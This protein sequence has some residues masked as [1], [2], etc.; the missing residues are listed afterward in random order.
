[1]KEKMKKIGT[2][3]GHR[4]LFEHEPNIS[5]T[6]ILFVRVRVHHLLEPNL[7]VQV[8]V[9]AQ[10]PRTRTEPNPGQSIDTMKFQVEI[11][12]MALHYH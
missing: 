4:T 11:T 6:N 8:R 12:Y 1:M 10:D 5:N 9:R 3:F 2:F 7:N